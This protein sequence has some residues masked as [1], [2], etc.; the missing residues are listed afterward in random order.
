MGT[1]KFSHF[2]ISLAL[3]RK[4]AVSFKQ[5]ST[6][7]MLTCC[8]MYLL[9]NRDELLKTT[10]L[11]QLDPAEAGV[12]GGPYPFGIDPVRTLPSSAVL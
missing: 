2:E 7:L 12:F 11:L 6:L 4:N 9:P 10:P 8:I 3:T 1:F 5:R